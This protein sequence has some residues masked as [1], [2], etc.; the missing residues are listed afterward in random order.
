MHPIIYDVAVS[1]DGFI[2]GP[3]AEISAF[4]HEGDIV[5]DYLTRL[6]NYKTV[7]MGRATYE[8]G[9]RFG[10]DP[11]ANPYPWARSIVVSSGLS[12]PGDRADVELW[13]DLPL[14]RLTALRRDSAG[15][16]YLCGGGILAGYLLDL[17]QID[18]LRLKRAPILLGGGTPLFAPHSC[19]ANLRLLDQRDYSAGLL[20]QEFALS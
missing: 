14:D 20:Y 12:L 3:G 16:I 9:Y 8:F 10:L 6:Q 7:L 11:G 18:I 15:P 13:P 2:A 19:A 17:G 4:P 1:A 5:A